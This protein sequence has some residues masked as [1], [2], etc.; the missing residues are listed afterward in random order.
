MVR[1]DH[2]IQRMIK[3]PDRGISWSIQELYTVDC[4]LAPIQVTLPVVFNRETVQLINV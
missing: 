4:A 2:H 3:N 1:G